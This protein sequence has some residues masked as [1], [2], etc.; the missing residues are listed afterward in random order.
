ME[1]HAALRQLMDQLT[2]A[3]I[4]CTQCRHDLLD[5]F[6]IGVLNIG[7]GRIRQQL[8]RQIAGELI[9]IREQ[10]LLVIVDRLELLAIRRDAADFD[11]GAVEVALPLTMPFLVCLG[12][13]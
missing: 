7:A 8:G 11:V 5:H 6:A 3:I 9:F 2:E 1:K 10:N 13:R 12:A 4:L